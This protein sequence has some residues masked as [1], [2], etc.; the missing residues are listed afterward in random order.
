[1]FGSKKNI[2]YYFKAG[3]SVYYEKDKNNTWVNK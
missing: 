3:V 1:M 2:I